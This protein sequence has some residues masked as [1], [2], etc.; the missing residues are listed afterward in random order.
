MLEILKP[1]FMN[2]NNSVISNEDI[3]EIKNFIDEVQ[4]TTKTMTSVNDLNIVIKEFESSYAEIEKENN[5]LKYQIDKKDDEI[6]Y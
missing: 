3:N 1:A 2:K 4:E 5:S 6:K